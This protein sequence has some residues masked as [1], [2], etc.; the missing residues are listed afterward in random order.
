MDFLV[1]VVSLSL[2][3]IALYLGL[4]KPARH[5]NN[6]ALKR[7][8]GI[9]NLKS[10]PNSNFEVGVK[11]GVTQAKTPKSYS[12]E[13]VESIMTP[14]EIKY[15]NHLQESV[16]ENLMIFTKV[17]LLDIFKPT[18]KKESFGAMKKISSKHVDFLICCSNSFKP[19][20]AIELDDSSHRQVEAQKRD[21]FVNGL[22]ESSGLKLFRVECTNNYAVDVTKKLI[23]NHVTE[24]DTI[25]SESPSME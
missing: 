14:A 8:S 5:R 20:F 25:K 12:Y 9:N 1:T 22:F 2:I 3:L 13:T 4:I 19:H 10:N 11:A 23:A 18:N 7:S 17:R 24:S 16:D 21:I 6:S 15:F